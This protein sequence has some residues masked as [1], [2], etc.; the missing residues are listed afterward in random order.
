MLLLL[1]FLKPAPVVLDP[2][3]TLY[4]YDHCPFCVRV[5][6]GLG[7]KNIKYDL[8]FMAND[9][10]TTPTSK[11]GKKIAPI[12]EEEGQAPFAESLDI[13]FYVDTHPKFGVTKLFAPLSD[14][15]DLKSWMKSVQTPLRKLQRPRYVKTVLPEFAFESARDTFV[16]NHQLPP[17]EK[18]DW[19]DDAQF[20]MDTR[21]N[22]YNAVLSE[23]PALIAEVNQKLV[24][25]EPLI[26]SPEYCTEGGLSMDDIDLWARLR[27]ITL[28]KGIIYPPKVRA[29]LDYFAD[30][31]DVPLY[32]SIAL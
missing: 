22:M 15:T 20:T 31:G 26:Y 13:L 9:D 18:K 10:V 32:D 6:L 19:K 17:Y 29:Y 12:Y 5:R 4:V 24:E 14:R 11:V 27:S 28:I 25:L 8:R 2:L 21:W 30:N 23:S 16:K 3:P 7:L 1:G